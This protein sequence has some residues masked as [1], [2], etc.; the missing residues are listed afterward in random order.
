M[1]GR[2]NT[3]HRSSKPTA[4]EGSDTVHRL[5]LAWHVLL[6]VF[7]G[8]VSI[9]DD[10]HAYDALLRWMPEPIVHNVIII[11]SLWAGVRAL[12][13]LLASCC[14]GGMH[15]GW[16]WLPRLSWCIFVL[17]TD[18]KDGYTWNAPT[19]DA[20][21]FAGTTIIQLMIYW[22]RHGLR[23]QD[24][25]PFIV[26]QCTSPT[27]DGASEDEEEEDEQTHGRY[28]SKSSVQMSRTGTKYEKVGNARLR[29]CNESSL[30][31]HPHSHVPTL[32]FVF[33]H[34][35][36]HPITPCSP[37]PSFA[38][39]FEA[40]IAMSIA[41]S[42]ECDRECSLSIHSLI[43]NGAVIVWHVSNVI[44]SQTFMYIQC[45]IKTMKEEEQ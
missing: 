20:L 39:C 2:S 33:I 13:H 19:I 6:L 32:N 11:N 42:Q 17:W 45:I 23:W 29:G 43:V 22:C 30:L 35:S 14:H 44:W 7:Q 40:C 24:F 9:D 28:R 16:F 10:G 31:V 8:I 26:M 36:L 41:L 3:S 5:L 1:T 15:A 25:F 18:R 34:S 38:R 21:F 4:R 12:G 27:V 37:S